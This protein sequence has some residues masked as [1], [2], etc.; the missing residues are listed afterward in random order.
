MSKANNFIV[1]SNGLRPGP[2][3]NLSNLIFYHFPPTMQTSVLFL[4]HRPILR[5]LYCYF[6]FPQI[7]RR[8]S[9][10]FFHVQY[11]FTGIP[12]LNILHKTVTTLITPTLQ[13]SSLPIFLFNALKRIWHFTYSIFV[14]VLTVPSLPPARMF[15]R[16]FCPLCSLLYPW[17]LEMLLAQ[18]KHTNIGWMNTNT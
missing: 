18:S 16:D 12:S 10:Y 11:H 9:T 5:A 14:C 17:H 15:N 3:D 7:S 2:P 6:L 1:A 13:H 8:V 4:K